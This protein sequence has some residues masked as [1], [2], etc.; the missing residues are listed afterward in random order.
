[1]NTSIADLRK[2]YSL[3]KLSEEEVSRSPIQQF[4][5][6]WDEA[7]ESE[8]S[9]V[10]AMTLATCDQ[11]G[12]PSARIVLLK[13]IN[14]D[15]FIFYTNYESRKGKELKE[16]PFASL[17]FF[18]KELERQVRIEGSISMTSIKDSDAYFISRPVKSKISCWSS[19]QSKVVASRQIL[20][21]K[22]VDY[23]DEFKD[24]NIPRPPHWGGYILFPSTIEFWQGRRSR[25]HDRIRYTGEGSGWLIERLAP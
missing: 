9:E 19:P 22:V 10:N 5:K 8:I 21:N 24:G 1:M 25:L 3:K 13:G 23:E 20:E 6:W 16:N 4:Q 2:D 11:H 17:V 14:E 18:W 15:G 12:K 7:I